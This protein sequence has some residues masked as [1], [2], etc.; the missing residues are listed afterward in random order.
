MSCT[1]VV[2]AGA[3]EVLKQ[4]DVRRCAV[5]D[6]QGWP[7][8]IASSIRAGLAQHRHDEAC[9]FMVA[10]QPFIG[11]AD[12]DQLIVYHQGSRDAIIALQAGDVW[13]TPMLFSSHDFG[14]LSKL[15]GDSGAKRYAQHQ[16]TRIRFVTAHSHDAFKDVDTIDDYR[17]LTRAVIESENLRTPRSRARRA[18][19][20]R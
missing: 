15:H 7:E 16:L 14:P 3:E 13:G 9:I 6:N 11:A 20:R 1:L 2:G 19:R 12:I 8:G 10:D 4:I 5:V 17:R 18:L